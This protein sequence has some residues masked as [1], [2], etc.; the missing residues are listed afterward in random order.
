MVQNLKDSACAAAHLWT[1]YNSEKK[2][3]SNN[4]VPSSSDSVLFTVICS[5]NKEV[6]IGKNLNN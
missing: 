1:E 6:T 2:N 5:P 3:K 4:K